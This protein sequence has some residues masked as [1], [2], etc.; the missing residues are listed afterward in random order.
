M[1]RQ[2]ACRCAVVP[3]AIPAIYFLGKHNW[4]TSFVGVVWPLPPRG[5]FG[6]PLQCP[7]KVC[8]LVCPTALAGGRRGPC[9]S[10]LN[11]TPS[12]VTPP[13]VTRNP[14]LQL[15]NFLGGWCRW[16]AVHE[17]SIAIA[18]LSS[19]FI[20]FSA[21]VIICSYSSI[22]QRWFAKHERTLACSIAVQSN[23]AGWCLGAVL[24][25]YSV[26]DV[27]GLLA[28]QFWQGVAITLTL[29][30]FLLFH[31]EGPPGHTSNAEHEHEELSAGESLC[32]LLGNGQFCMQCICYAVLA[33]V[34]FGVPGFQTSAFSHILTERQTAWT[35]CSFILSGVVVG[36]A[37][38]LFVKDAS[39]FPSVLK[40]MFVAASASLVLLLG[41][42]AV[43]TSFSHDT[44]FTLLLLA[45][46]ICGGS[47]LG[48]IGPCRRRLAWDPALPCTALHC[49]ALHCTVILSLAAHC[50]AA[51]P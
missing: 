2:L 49:T 33:G 40:A 17:G 31:R 16:L 25:P 47:S 15:C 3:A 44:V 23:Y 11:G 48:F 22:S 29:L 1:T 7:P 42:F 34:S 4:R 9:P 12:L 30:L 14:W 51:P 36:L 13:F 8:T 35:N 45:M 37:A 19:I 46:A 6:T 28:F 43:H 5:S 18:V 41:I 32:S 20:G 50:T 21:S 24:I 27:A 10:L 38:G 26:K 39:S